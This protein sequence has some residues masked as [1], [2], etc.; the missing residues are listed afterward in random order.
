VNIVFT[1]NVCLAATS[2]C[3]RL[4]LRSPHER[5]SDQSPIYHPKADDESETPTLVGQASMLHHFRSSYLILISFPLRQVV[6]RNKGV[7]NSFRLIGTRITREHSLRWHKFVY[8]SV[9]YGLNLFLKRKYKALL[10]NWC[11]SSITQPQH[12]MASVH[13][14]L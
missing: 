5:I 11:L 12:T 14:F 3:I 1:K 7:K 10:M 6:I 8:S 13:S 4:M 9:P 2:V